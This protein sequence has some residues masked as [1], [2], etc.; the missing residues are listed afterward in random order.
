MSEPDTYDEFLEICEVL[1]SNGKTPIIVGGS[2]LWHMEFWTNH[3]LRMD[4]LKEDPDWLEQ[5]L[6]GRESWQDEKTYAMFEHIVE[7]FNSGY[8]DE[9]WQS[10]PDGSLPYLMAQNNTGMLYTGSWTI[11]TVQEINPD[12]EIGWFY[13]PDEE[14][15]VVVG[16]NRD[17]FWGVTKSVQR[18]KKN[19]R[20]Q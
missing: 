1:Q 14:G 15:D 3:F 20:Q 16:E 17:V 4:V 18:T 11:A 5:S 2:D 9:S 10:T 19:M 13:L 12:I 8:V 7:L 6:A